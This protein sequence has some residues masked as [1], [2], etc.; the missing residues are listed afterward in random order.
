MGKLNQNRKGMFQR[1]HVEKLI[2]EVEAHAAAGGAVDRQRHVEPFRR[3][4]NRIKVSV[5]V[6]FVQPGNGRQQAGDQ[7]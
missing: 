2:E 6:A 7:P 3:F 4:I 5:A 1:V